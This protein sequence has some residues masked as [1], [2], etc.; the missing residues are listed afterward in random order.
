[1]KNK[2]DNSLVKTENPQEKFGGSR[3]WKTRYEATQREIEGTKRE[4][5]DSINTIVKL[6]DQLKQTRQIAF[7]L[8]EEKDALL[9]F[10]NI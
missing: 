5:R 9:G 10:E 2:S 7:K 1:M 4:L 8:R 6:Q 3:D